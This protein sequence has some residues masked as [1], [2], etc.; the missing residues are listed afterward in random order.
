MEAELEF[1]YSNRVQDLVET[2]EG[3]KPIGCKLVY[4]QKR[5]VDGKVK[6][7]KAR[8]VAKSYSQKPSFKYEEAFALV[9]VFKS[10]KILLSIVVHLDYEI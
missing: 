9:A 2:P 1:M 4:K 10:I 8:L 7:Y 6:T 5:G 3:I